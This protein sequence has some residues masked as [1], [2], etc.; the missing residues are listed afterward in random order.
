MQG[1]PIRWCWTDSYKRSKVTSNDITFEKASVLFNIGALY[2]HMAVNAIN[3]VPIVP[4]DIRCK[5]SRSSTAR[6]A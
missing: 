3:V 4:L 5:T 2:T 6:I 1:I